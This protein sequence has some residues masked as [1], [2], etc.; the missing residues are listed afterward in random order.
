MK[1]RIR[2]T[3]SELHRLIKESV[4]NILSELDWKTYAN[5]AKKRYKQAS[6][7][8]RDKNKWEKSK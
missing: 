4:N 7:N 2:L 6:L 1:Q 3:E 5:A 8:L